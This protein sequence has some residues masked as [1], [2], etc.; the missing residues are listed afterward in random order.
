MAK[1][2]TLGHLAALFTIIV[3]GTT[4]VCTK[5]LLE[6]FTP[7]EILIFR[8]ALGFLA[9]CL[10]S[11]HRL[12]G[13]TRKQE[14]LFAAAGLTGVCLYYFLEN[15]ALVYTMASNVGVITATAALFSA[16]FAYL[17]TD[18]KGLTPRFLLGFVLAI[19]GIA[20]ISFNGLELHLN[21]LGDFLALGSS[22]TWGIYS[23]MIKKINKYGYSTL[24]STKRIFA[25][26]MFFLLFTIPGSGSSWDMARLLDV[27][28]LLGL[29]FL[30]LIASALCF[31][32]WN[33][34]VKEI[35]AISAS[36]YLYLNTVVTII[37][38][39][40][41]LGEPITAKSALGTL[42]VLSGLVISEQRH[43]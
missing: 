13:V 41:V 35:G 33:Y 20:L 4:F 16:F 23:V 3:W 42:L 43:K 10:M 24:Q 7:C 34:A 38:S 14:M 5:V 12:K 30:G 18:E 40:L 15:T 21:P 32:T 25:W 26:G 22:L 37:A 2:R 29:L 36:V 28:N 11:H 6:S 8:F 39:F 17:F 9:L 31:L 1:S 19:S 27:Q